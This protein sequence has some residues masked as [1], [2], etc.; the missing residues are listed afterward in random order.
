MYLLR[1]GA[2][3]EKEIYRVSAS[4][5]TAIHRRHHSSSL[6]AWPTA[7]QRC[8]LE[9][10]ASCEHIDLN[11]QTERPLPMAS[12]LTISYPHWIHIKCPDQ[13]QTLAVPP[14][15]PITFQVLPNGQTVP[16]PM[17]FLLVPAKHIV[18]QQP[19][20]ARVAPP[21]QT[22]PKSLVHPVERHRQPSPVS[23]L[24]AIQTQSKQIF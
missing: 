2:K 7:T 17:G 1:Q 20:A 21:N 4:S 18:P 15:H 11:R 16:V 23:K 14:G 13:Q 5:S 6:S 22:K 9:R 8:P 19:A 10:T 12:S 3:R 24:N